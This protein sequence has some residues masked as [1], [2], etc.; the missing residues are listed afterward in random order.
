MAKLGEIVKKERRRAAVARY[1]ARRAVLKAVAR[2]PRTPEE[3]RRTARRG[4]SHRPRD[5]GHK[6]GR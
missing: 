6:A 5:A 3:A 4:L 1:A 2:D